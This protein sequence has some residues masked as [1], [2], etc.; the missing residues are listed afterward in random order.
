MSGAKRDWLALAGKAMRK[1]PHVVARRAWRLF[2]D[3]AERYASSI[4]ADSLNERAL[5]KKLNADSMGELWARL[6][7]LPYPAITEPVKPDVY[8]KLIPGDMARILKSAD[9]AMNRRINLLGSGLV[10][11]GLEPDWSRDPKTGAAWP[12]QYAF[13][14]DYMNLDRPSDVK[15][16]WEISRHQWLIPLGQA[17]LLTGA[18]KYAAS[19]REILDHW[20][21]NN[22]YAHSVNWAIAMEPAMRIFTWTWL[23]HAFKTSAA[24][25]DES[26]RFRYLKTLYLSADFI[27]RHME[28]A[29][30]NGNHYL[31][32]AGGLVFAGLFFND[33]VAPWRW[34]EVGWK[35]LNKEISIQVLT[36]GVDYE[37]S[38]PYHRFVTEMFLFPAL[39]RLRRGLD[40]SPYYRERLSAMARFTSA[41]TRPDGTAPVIG[42]AD[43]G[44]V[45][46]FGGQG[47][48][49]H[50]HIIGII[51]GA[52]GDKELRKEFSGDKSEAFWVLGDAADIAAKPDT[53]SI[54]FPDA[55]VYI[56]KSARSHVYIDCGPVGLKNLGGH[57]HNDCLSFEAFLDGTPL[58]VD[59]GS[60]V[61][62]ASPEWR[63]KF[64]GT[65]F[66]NTPMIDGEEQNRF[67]GP[68]ELWRLH[69]DAVPHVT[70]WETS[71]D[72]DLFTG[73]HDGYMRLTTPLKPVRTI[74]LDKKK[75]VLLISDRFIGDGNHRISIPYHLAP[76]VTAVEGEKGTLEL[77]KDGRRF[78]FVLS[79]A[80]EW[81]M[82]LRKGWYSPSYGVKVETQLIELTREG[83]LVTATVAVGPATLDKKEIIEFMGRDFYK[84]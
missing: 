72:L 67:A 13:D 9:D 44:R 5:L 74:V 4:R 63:N 46:P 62:T 40:V 38:I 73:S 47:I 23:F 16:P 29:P 78:Q 37:G 34:A 55:G 79:E 19:A 25:M 35:I 36:D 49:D 65:A 50:R 60:Y 64:R 48:N 3:W 1:P 14:I 59:C 83:P 66:H 30:V 2:T 32:N 42:D 12:N 52:M 57:G 53:T 68:G 39:Y 8:E 76:G 84:D 28:W 45:L 80:D 24:W 7:A 81:K 61:Y 70:R 71:G 56:M 75:E 51:S 82:T 58:I 27:E 10:E 15:M 26:F 18:E 77:L 33:G 17:Y 22:P 69:Y 43:D 54:F 6:S 31:S 11:L 41:Y 20:I 21:A